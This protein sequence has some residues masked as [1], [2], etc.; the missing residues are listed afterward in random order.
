MS[1]DFRPPS[2]AEI[3]QAAARLFTSES[4]IE[5]D[6]HVVRAIALLNELQN[7]HLQLVFS[8]GTSLAKAG[9]I[10]RF[11]EDVDFRAVIKPTTR[12]R[13]RE[14]RD[15][16]I[17]TFIAQHFTILDPPIIADGSKF[18]SLRLDYTAV[19]G[20]NSALRPYLR[21]EVS[22]TPPRIDPIHRPVQSLIGQV[23][24]HDIEI[25]SMPFVDPVEI[26][27]DKLSAL[28]W[29]LL[30]DNGVTDQSL[31]RHVHDLAALEPMIK[32]NNF[33]SDLV[34]QA[35]AD[36]KGRGGIKDSTIPQ[37]LQNIVQVLRQEASWAHA[38][39]NFVQQA[40]FA[41]DDDQI[42]FLN[43]LQACERLIELVD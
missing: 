15:R 30:S 9:L 11:S 40:S 35:F 38:Y 1:L 13:Y 10:K 23:A 14:E 24:G 8:G 25:S 27:A 19:F 21:V 7:D 12:N 32:A 17:A 18:F 31:V 34:Y 37:R 41:R 28:A 3:E 36:D 4:F 26:A 33:F 5:K 29:R 22:F 16:I 20:G 42:S 6:W 2:K 43:A 39:Q